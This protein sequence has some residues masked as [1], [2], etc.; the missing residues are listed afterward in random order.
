MKYLRSKH[1][2]EGYRRSARLTWAAD[3]VRVIRAIA[4]LVAHLLLA[5][6]LLTVGAREFVW[7]TYRAVHFVLLI[8][9]VLDAVAM[10]RLVVAPVTFPA[11]RQLV[12]VETDG[13]HGGVLC[14]L[15][16]C[17]QNF[18]CRA[19]GWPPLCSCTQKK[20]R[21]TMAAEIGPLAGTHEEKTISSGTINKNL[22][23][24][25]KHFSI[26]QLW[27]G[28]NENNFYEPCL[29]PTIISWLYK[30]VCPHLAIHYLV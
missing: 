13:A 25:L 24:S 4:D 15:T 10:L 26:R 1:K 20:T 23:R 18:I 11:A 16:I 28:M 21:L 30:N 5:I 12:P 8:G 14:A 22:Y 27:F 6:A 17:T 2:A 29:F 3:F 7:T 9:T 19:L